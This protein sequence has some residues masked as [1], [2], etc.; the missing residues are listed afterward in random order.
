MVT[1]DQSSPCCGG[2]TAMDMCNEEAISP[3]CWL[4]TS[5]K[6]IKIIVRITER[7]SRSREV[8]DVTKLGVHSGIE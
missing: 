5:K 7:V 6:V 2:L 1:T 8:C 3:K 4:L